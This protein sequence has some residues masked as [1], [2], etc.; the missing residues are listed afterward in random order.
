MTG[1]YNDPHYTREKLLDYHREELYRSGISDEVIQAAGI[2]SATRAKTLQSL[3]FKGDQ[4]KLF[5]AM[6]F[7]VY[8]VDGGEPLYHR[9]KPDSPRKP[10]YKYEQPAGKP[11]TIYVPPM[12]QSGLSDPSRPLYITE[13]EKKA[14]SAAS[15]GM[16]CIALFGVDCWKGT[17][18][19]GGKTVLSELNHI[20]YNDR[21]VYLT[22]DSEWVHNTHVAMALIGLKTEVE[23]RK[24]KGLIVVFPG[25]PD[26]SKVGMDDF[27][28]QGKNELDLVA[29][30][31]DGMPDWRQ[32]RSQQ[33]ALKFNAN[34]LPMIETNSRQLREMTSD[35]LNALVS[36][37]TPPSVF[38]RSGL[39]RVTI[40]EQCTASVQMLTIDSLRGRMARTA[41]W[42]STSEKRGVIEVSPPA[43]VVQ[44]LLSLHEWPGVPPLRGVVTA[45]CFSPGGEI[46]MTSGYH[47]ASRLY[48]HAQPPLQLPELQT[49]PDAVRDAVQLLCVEWLGQFPFV[50]QSSLAHAI[51][52][53]L[54]PFVREMIDG[55]T[56]LHL[57]DAPSPGSGKS[58]GAKVLT[59]PF[60]PQGPMLM[61][62]GNDEDEWRKRITATLNAGPSH[63]LIDNVR[64]KLSSSSL[65][66]VLTLT[67]W[68]DRILGSSETTGLP[69]RGV[70]IATGNNVQM[71]D[72][73][74]RRSI[75]IRLDPKVDRPWLR[76]G[77][78]HHLEV[79][80]PEHRAE[81]VSAALT[82]V[83]AW[84]NAGCPQFR[85]VKM[86]SFE[87]WSAVMGG[88][89]DNAGVGGF[90]DNATE[91]YDR[92]DPER[93]SWCN[94]FERWHDKY[95]SSAVGVKDLF[96]MVKADDLLP[97]VLGDTDK[98][99]ACKVQLGALLRQKLD[100]IYDGFRLEKAGEA[101]RATLYRVVK[102]TT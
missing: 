99:Q 60:A 83:Q 15:R 84:I 12:C 67:R 9:I 81:L 25:N 8:G 17:N 86:G 57:W 14:L 88:I 76:N 70:W 39:V 58:L 102:L 82:L 64:R 34:A 68:N 2:S 45:P 98:E 7:P 49:S 96:A 6:V 62:E 11:V 1:D 69:N 65:A 55:P 44:D 63:I 36:Q 4:A 21:R 50:G 24:A 100:R 97:E 22:F 52:Q 46:E 77:F 27:F 26:G 29:L 33:A 10:K 85:R 41:D 74:T 38:A 61:T 53:L 66:S 51:A 92:L 20:A 40:D 87:R 94:F 93:E 78:R 89:L 37:N 28:M 95:G 42:M 47:A 19:Y 13:G 32:I 101:Q 72:E 3:G 18:Q 73:I 90:L 5:P 59:L 56:P 35:A 48:Y 43:A 31:M 71:T 80:T 16:L 54:L 23:R 30:A 75:W 91:L 79:W